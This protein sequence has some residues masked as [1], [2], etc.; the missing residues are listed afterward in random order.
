MHPWIN[1]I[2]FIK[3]K[4]KIPLKFNV[5]KFTHAENRIVKRIRTLNSI[6]KCYENYKNI[7][8]YIKLTY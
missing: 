8:I 6:N 1:Q 7:Y 5:K 3:K 2:T 4:K